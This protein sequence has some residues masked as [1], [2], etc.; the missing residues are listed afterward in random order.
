M[1]NVSA[2]MTITDE[3]IEKTNE[4]LITCSKCMTSKRFVINSKYNQWLDATEAVSE[5]IQPS[6]GSDKLTNKL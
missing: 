4:C 1:P 5:I 3:P 6:N 2:E